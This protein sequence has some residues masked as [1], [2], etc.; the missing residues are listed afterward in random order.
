MAILSLHQDFIADGMLRM[1]SFLEAEWFNSNK[2]TEHVQV[3]TLSVSA[4]SGFTAFLLS[5]IEVNEASLG[6]G[7]RLKKTAS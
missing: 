5:F 3:R 7:S 6:V 1:P 4:S 2:C